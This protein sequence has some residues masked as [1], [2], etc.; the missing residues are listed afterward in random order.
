MEITKKFKHSVYCSKVGG[1]VGITKKF[2]HSVYCSKL[3]GWGHQETQTTCLLQEGGWVMFTK[4]FRH[5]VYCSKV[6]GWRSPRSSSTLST[7]ARWVGGWGSPR[8]SDT[9][10]TAARWVGWA[11]K[12]V[13]TSCK[14]VGWVELTKKSNHQ[15]PFVLQQGGWVVRGADQEVQLTQLNLSLLFVFFQATANLV[16]SKLRV[17]EQY[18]NALPMNQSVTVEGVKVTLLEANQYVFFLKL[19]LH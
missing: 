4:K 10:S 7:A 14:M 3:G 2:K 16:R 13:E 15:S 5:P 6:A 9:L 11:H 19:H 17:E 1:W 8:S 18:I 12:E